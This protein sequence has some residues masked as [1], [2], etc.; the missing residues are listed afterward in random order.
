MESLL[1]CFRN[2]NA[3]NANIFIHVY[4][5][6]ISQDGLNQALEDMKSD[7]PWVEKLDLTVDA[8]PPPKPM[9]PQLGA[10]PDDLAGEGVHDDFKR[11]MKL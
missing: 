8:L 1:L 3:S 9:V 2:T 10:N 5:T 4:V 6:I 7:M 11:E